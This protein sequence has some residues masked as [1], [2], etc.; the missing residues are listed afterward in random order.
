MESKYTSLLENE[1]YDD[2]MDFF[3]RYNIVDER[4]SDHTE[5]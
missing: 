3:S 5:K 1:W 4:I 2:Y